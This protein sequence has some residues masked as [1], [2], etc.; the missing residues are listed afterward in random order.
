MIV[1]FSDSTF[2]QE[3]RGI[4]RVRG[5]VKDVDGNPLEG[6]EITALNI[7]FELSFKSESDKKGHWSVGGLGSGAYRFSASLE[8]YEPAVYDTKVTQNFMN[9]EVIELVMKKVEKIEILSGMDEPENRALF[10]EGMKLFEE[11][12]F[13]EA[14]SKFQDFL[15]KAPH[16]YQANINIGNCYKELREYDKALEAFKLVLHNIQ[17]ENGSLQG[18]ETAALALASIGETYM[19]M[20]DFTAARDYLQQALDVY[21]QDP[22]IAYKIGEIYFKRGDTD[23]GIAYYQKAIEFKPDWGAPY[24]Q[25]GYAYLNKGEYQK[26]VDAF[27]KYLEIDPGS[28][29][30]ATVKALIPQIEGMIKK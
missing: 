30:A 16:L 27:N 18:E 10:E 21:P 17:R 8:G 6:V 20:E 28:A 4:G 23:N 25:L 5:T 12:M 14:L 13:A 1:G 11:E 19:D 9:N 26:A 7:K 2:A 29:Q 15:A 24:R 3:G 22:T